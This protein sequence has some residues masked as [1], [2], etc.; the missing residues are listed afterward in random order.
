M[1][2]RL[3]VAVIAITCLTTVP[4]SAHPGRTASSQPPVGSARSS[5]PLPRVPVAA[6][7]TAVTSHITLVNHPADHS[8]YVDCLAGGKAAATSAACLRAAVHDF[9][10]AR[11]AEHLA[12]LVLP[13][14]FTHLTEQG[15]LFVLANLERTAR[16]LPAF[17]RLSTTLDALSGSGALHDDDPSPP[18]MSGIYRWGANWAG[19]YSTLLAEYLWMYDD[20]PGATNISCTRTSTAGCWGHRANILANYPAP[21]IMGAA[22]T[23][24]DRYHGSIAEEFLGGTPA[25]TMR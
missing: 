5:R 13:S 4:A 9:D 20:G 25:E 12:P 22:A 19:T 7:A 6:R 15:Q 18:R 17:T 8:F 1:T 23:T 10:L 16:H 21:R 3:L 2:R 14:T 24:T 11:S